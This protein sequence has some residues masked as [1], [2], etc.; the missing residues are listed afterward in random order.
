[1]T[2]IVSPQK[3]SSTARSFRPSSS[4]PVGGVP[5][6]LCAISGRVGSPFG[7]VIGVLSATHFTSVRCRKPVAGLAVFSP[8]ASEYASRRWQII[9]FADIFPHSPRSDDVSVEIRISIDCRSVLDSSVRISRHCNPT[10]PQLMR[11][12]LAICDRPRKSLSWTPTE[13]YVIRPLADSEE[14]IL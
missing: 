12:P 7:Q 5:P 8:S 6:T 1:M 2:S 10:W 3:R 9:S 11:L 14:N 4:K 13:T